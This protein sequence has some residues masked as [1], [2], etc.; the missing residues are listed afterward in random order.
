M[1]TD[2]QIAIKEANAE[3]L[4]SC[5]ELVGSHIRLEEASYKFEGVVKNVKYI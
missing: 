2:Y 4:K 5:N 3:L 1:V